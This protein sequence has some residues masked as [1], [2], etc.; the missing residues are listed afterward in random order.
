MS[1]LLKHGSKVALESCCAFLSVLMTCKILKQALLPLQAASWGC[2]KWWPFVL[3]STS[4]SCFLASS[5]EDLHIL[6][7]FLA[8]RSSQNTPRIMNRYRTFC[9]S[10]ILGKQVVL[11]W[12]SLPSQL[13]SNVS[14]ARS[15]P[16]I[17]IL[18]SCFPVLFDTVCIRFCSYPIPIGWGLAFRHSAQVM[19]RF[20][21]CMDLTNILVLIVWSK[22]ANYCCQSR[23]ARHRPFDNAWDLPSSN[24]AT[25]LR[26]KIGCRVMSRAQCLA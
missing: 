8:V 15:C 24:F 20:A 18:Y 2:L 19:K 13:R 12:Y 14:Q 10:I 5:L 3:A 17:K 11:M 21:R 25:S 6:S 9:L 1:S 23:H 4:R 7:Q 26:Q 16:D 22:L